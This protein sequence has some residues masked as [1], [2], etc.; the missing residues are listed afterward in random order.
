MVSRYFTHQYEGSMAVATLIDFYT[1]FGWVGWVAGSLGLGVVLAQL[2][3]AIGHIAPGECRTLA[4]VFAFMFCVNTA[5]ASITGALFGYGGLFFL[6][7]WFVVSRKKTPALS[8]G[9][10]VMSPGAGI[11]LGAR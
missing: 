1:A 9:T 10:Q 3:R 11:G 7:L 6:G 8:P 5:E 2:D 4:L